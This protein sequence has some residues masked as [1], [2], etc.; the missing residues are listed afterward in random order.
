MKIEVFN[1]SG[2]KNLPKL[3]LAKAVKYALRGEGRIHAEINIVLLN[4]A[5]IKEMNNHYLNHD[6]PTDVISFKM[7]NDPLAGEIYIGAEI[8]IQQAIEYKVSVTN[9]LMR[10][11]IHGALHIVG[12]EDDSKEKKSVMSS[13]EDLYIRIIKMED[14]V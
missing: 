13:L 10:L 8:A 1:E 2:I 14:Y 7:E 4:N 6:Y 9:E 11:A 5:D 3:K 12:Y